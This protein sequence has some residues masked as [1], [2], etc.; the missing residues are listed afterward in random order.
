[1]IIKNIEQKLKLTLFISILSVITGLA[2][3][4]AGLS[5]GYKTS[6]DALRNIYVT[7]GEVTFGAERMD[8]NLMFDIGANNMIKTFHSKFFNLPP[9]EKYIEYTLNEAMYLIDDSG[10]R[11]RNALIDRGFYSEILS[12]SATFSVICD[13]VSIDRQNM[14]FTFYGRQIIEKKNSKIMRELIT[15]GGIREV[16]RTQNNPFGYIIT[17]YKT[18]S[19]KDLS[20]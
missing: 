10:M 17:N 20:L 16:Q 5:Y 2:L 4:I 15:E 3:A 19:N 7:S 12:L 8:K 18:I 1:M 14:T 11:Q 6:S 13:S 9:D